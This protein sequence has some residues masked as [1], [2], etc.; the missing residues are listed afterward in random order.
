MVWGRPGVARCFAKRSGERYFTHVPSVNI[1]GGGR[2]GGALAIA[3]DRAGYPIE[4]VVYR[5]GR[6]LDTLKA[7]LGDI[8]FIDD[9]S[10]LGPADVCL[11][12]S[13]DPEI[14]GIAQ[15]LAGL[16]R[17]PKFAF[18]T[19]GSLTSAEL[20]ALAAKGVQTASLHPLAAISDPVTGSDRFRGAYFCIEGNSD[21]VAFAESIVRDLGGHPFSIPTISKPLY[22]ASAVMSAGHIVALLDGAI[23][24]MRNCGLSAVDAKSILIPLAASSLANLTEKDPSSA[25]TGPYA[26]GDASALV[27]HLEAFENAGISPNLRRI[28]LELALRSLEI[29]ATGGRDFAALRESILIA[30]E[31]A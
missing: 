23:E 9:A 3:L 15:E 8:K 6:F 7:V 30:K 14:K 10:R 29:A 2:V 22:H 28:Y 21:A 5:G 25:L 31:K 1:I 12:T 24:I 18:H 11:I 4:S 19:S 27:R 16:D 17:L 26:R 13:G 20:D